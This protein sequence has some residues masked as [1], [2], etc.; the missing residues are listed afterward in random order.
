[1]LTPDQARLKA[2]MLRRVRGVIASA[3]QMIHD[4]NYWNSTHPEDKPLDIELDR[5]VLYR[6]RKI[7]AML[8][9]NNGEDLD[10]TEVNLVIAAM[11][12]EQRQG[13]L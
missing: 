10:M 4:V 13:L 8:E 1:M 12:E 2:L 7:E 3:Q 11:M 5:V 6:F 9:R